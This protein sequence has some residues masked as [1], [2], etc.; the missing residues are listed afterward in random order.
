MIWMSTVFWRAE[1]LGLIMTDVMCLA[2]H[3]AV[4]NGIKTIFAREMKRLKGSG[5]NISYVVIK[6]FQL[7]PLRVFTPKR[8]R[9][10]SWISSSVFLNL[11]TR[12]G[13]IQHNSA[14]LYNC[15]ET[16]VTVV[17]HKHT[18]IRGC[19]KKF[20]DWTYRLECIYLI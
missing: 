19:I 5:W 12:K 14:R 1:F 2:Y 8:E 20:P 11:R 18:K 4:R 16:G 13:R 15:D 17:Q 7:Q 3:L 10:H 9:F 6:K